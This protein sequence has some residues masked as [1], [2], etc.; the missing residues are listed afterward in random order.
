MPYIP[1]AEG[2]NQA[3]H[4]LTHTSHQD[5]YGE[6]ESRIEEGRSEVRKVGREARCTQADHYYIS[7]R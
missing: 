2:D 6:E 3:F 1:P 5:T 4:Q 7:L